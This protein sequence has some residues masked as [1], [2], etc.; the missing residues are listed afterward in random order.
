MDII[1]QYLNLNV[2]KIIIDYLNP[3]PDLPFLNELETETILIYNDVM[4]WRCYQNYAIKYDNQYFNY[5][6]MGFK[7]FNS[8]RIRRY[9]ENI[10]SWIVSN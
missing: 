4:A 1:H 2:S 3:L 10:L 9:R 8:Y 7:A 5:H 6:E